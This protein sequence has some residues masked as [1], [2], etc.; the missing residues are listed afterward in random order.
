[1]ATAPHLRL[2]T[3]P[4]PL[5]PQAS[6]PAHGIA[7][8][9]LRAA[10]KEMRSA[11]ADWHGGRCFSLVYHASDAHTA[12]LKEAHNLFFEENGLNP[13]AF[14]S[15][16]RMESEVVRMAAALLHGDRQ[17]VGTMTSGGTESLL[18]AVKTARDLARHK[19]PWIRSPELIMPATAHVAFDKA[20]HY[21]GVKIR[22]APVGKDLRVDVRA[23]RKLINRNTILLVGSAP[24]YPHGVV[25]PIEELGALALEKDLLLHV[26]ACVGGFILPFLEKLGRP[27]PLWDFRVP[28]VT[29][30]SADLHKYGYTAKGASLILYRSMELLKHQFFVATEFP[31]GIYASPTLPGTR[32]GGSIAAAWAGILGLGED[33]YLALAKKA[34]D[35]ADGF[36]AG[37]GRIA[38]LEVLGAPH[39]T[40]VTWASTEKAV[41]IYAVADRLDDMGWHID[42]QQHPASLHLTVTANHADVVDEFLADVAKAVQ[43]VRENPALKTKGNAPMY[44]MMAKIPARGMVKS[45]VRKVMEEMYGADGG[46]PDLQKPPEGMIGKVIERYGD[47]VMQAL[48]ELEELKARLKGLRRG[49]SDRS[50]R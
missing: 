26:D 49:R 9:T 30:I 1:M 11:D 17:V 29:S 18:L 39:A 2:E 34:A 24:Q 23:V 27:V 48:D 6:I 41:D 46:A 25:D 16:K 22:R 4:E 31:G 50:D 3:A 5:P 42:R 15:L 37:L 45:A 47:R 43:L 8:D 7:H 10:M 44:G 14:K 12:F 36:R 38:G 21:F 28:G 13:M 33:G 32:P 40:I 35:A 20:S 19:R